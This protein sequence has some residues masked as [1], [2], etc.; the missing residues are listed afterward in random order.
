MKPDGRSQLLAFF[1]KIPVLAAVYF[2]S[3]SASAALV[4]SMG[5]RFPE[6][7]GH[8]WAPI[9]DFLGG[10][11]LVV[12]L[13][14][15]ARG[16]GGT[17]NKRWLILLAF[18]FFSFVINNQIEAAV[19]TTFHEVPTMLLFF[20][21]PSVVVTG[22]TV[23]LVK[24]SYDQNALESVFANRSLQSWWWRLLVAWFAFPVIYYFFGAL[25]YPFV[26]DVYAQQDS[27]LRVP[28]QVVVLGA[29]IVRSLLFLV[30]AIPILMNWKLSRRSLV[31]SLAATLAAMV[32]VAGMFEN[33]W[34]PTQLKI[35]HSLEIIADSLVHA[36]VLV[37]LLVP[38]QK[39][40]QAG[41]AES[42]Q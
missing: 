26:A 27:G 41:V 4:T 1:W 20:F 12:C 19:F 38:K 16:I 34:M 8:E 24:A 36:W 39:V 31:L 18:T 35:V 3:K 2:V 42:I 25:I 7:P 10:T 22:V 40:G 23:A 14:F 21:F 6:M 11:V 30:G 5:L 33:T 37:A 17:L 29:A 15:L 9:L 28:A 32:G 13:V